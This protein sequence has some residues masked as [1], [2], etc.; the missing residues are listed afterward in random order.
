MKNVY[1]FTVLLGVLFFSCSNDDDNP[2]S[3]NTCDALAEVV[4]EEDFNAISTANYEVT[5]IA[6]NDECLEIT[7]RSSGCEPESWEMNLYSVDAFYTVFPL[8]RVVKIELINEQLCQAVFQKTVSFNLT[9]FQVD[10]QNEIPLT[11]E[12]WDEQLIYEY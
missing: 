2:S 1:T 3:I 11:I 4:Y 12:G 6:F 8:Q 5:E 9:P 10:G 7:I